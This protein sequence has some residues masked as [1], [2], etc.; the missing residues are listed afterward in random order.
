MNAMPKFGRKTKQ[1]ST[2]GSGQRMLQRESRPKY[3]YVYLSPTGH[4]EAVVHSTVPTQYDYPT[5]NGIPGR[6]SYALD[7]AGNL[8]IRG[9]GRR[10]WGKWVAG[11]TRLPELHLVTLSSQDL[12]CDNF[13][14][15]YVSFVYQFRLPY[16]QNT[17]CF[18]IGSGGPCADTSNTSQVSRYYHEIRKEVNFYHGKRQWRLW[19]RLEWG[20][21]IK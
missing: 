19:K 3:E 10:L 11:K 9:L 6:R 21:G 12:P 15:S 17:F 20:F 18:D 16:T 7:G 5:S 1:R 4:G 8:K 13:G 14:D 2:R